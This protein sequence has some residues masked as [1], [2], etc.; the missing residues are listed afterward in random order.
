MDPSNFTTHYLLG[1]AYQQMGRKE[2]AKREM[3][4]VSSI[5]SREDK[6]LQ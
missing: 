5:H 4:A 2:D 6:S 3:N 1:K